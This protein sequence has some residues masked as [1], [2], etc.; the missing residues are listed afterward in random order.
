MKYILACFLIAQGLVGALIVMW[1][2][3]RAGF[4]FLAWALPLIFPFLSVAVG[5]TFFYSFRVG[6]FLSSPLLGAQI[7]HYYG[8]GIEYSFNIGVSGLFWY[9]LGN[10]MIGFN[11]VA[12]I[13]FIVILACAFSKPMMNS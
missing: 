9:K 2:A 7:L 8:E 10:S 11:Y 13:A 4:E 3:N 1:L 6:V 12:G 5:L